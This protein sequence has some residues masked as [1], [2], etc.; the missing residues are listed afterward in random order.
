MIS[1]L[2]SKRDWSI[3]ESNGENKGAFQRWVCAAIWEGAGCLSTTRTTTITTGWSIVPCDFLLF[4]LVFY[5]GDCVKWTRWQ[6]SEDILSQDAL[7]AE[8]QPSQTRNCNGWNVKHLTFFSPE[9]PR[10]AKG[11][12]HTLVHFTLFFRVLRYQFQSR[13]MF[14]SLLEK[15][16]WTALNCNWWLLIPKMQEQV[17]SSIVAVQNPVSV[18]QFLHSTRAL[19]SVEAALHHVITSWVAS[20]WQVTCTFA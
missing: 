15:H 11:V 10:D 13:A 6:A 1:V 14:Y 19:I 3:L 7:H 18:L 8:G 9:N 16:G 4:F 20:D 2:V 5:W 12:T 17:Q